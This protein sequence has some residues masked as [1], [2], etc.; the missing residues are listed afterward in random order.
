MMI[1]AGLYIVP[2]NTTVYSIQIAAGI[3]S[4]GLLITVFVSVIIYLR[5]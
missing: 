1:D 3:M 4:A 5:R 2:D